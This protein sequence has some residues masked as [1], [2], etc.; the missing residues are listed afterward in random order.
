MLAMPR[1]IHFELDATERICTGI[2]ERGIAVEPNFLP[3]SAIAALAAH[4]RQQDVAGEFHAAAIGREALRVEQRAIR[5]DRIAWLDETDPSPAVQSAWYA[6][7]ELRQ[8]LNA[9]LLLG[10][11][12]FE[13]HYAI[14]PPGA[15]YRRHR[16]RFR[17]DDARV[18]SCVLYLNRDWG[19]SDGGLLRIHIAS[20]ECCDVT[21]I[22]GTLVCFLSEQFEHEVL[23]ATR[24][25]LAL[26]GWFR[27][28]ALS[29]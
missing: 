1:P 2:A 26:T 7:S 15:S 27:R 25:R 16:D 21:P 23:P 10:L 8:A 9:A 28:R 3:A 6:L 18:L 22:G 29:A 13:G 12:A 17:D 14:Y 20:G 24:E 5:G 11:F 4:A 19:A